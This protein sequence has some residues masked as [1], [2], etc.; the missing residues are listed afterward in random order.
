MYHDVDFGNAYAGLITVGY[1]VLDSAGG[2]EIARTTSGVFEIG[3]GKYG[4]NVNLSATFAGTIYWDTVDG[5]SVNACEAI[6]NSFNYMLAMPGQ[7]T[8]SLTPS[9]AQAIMQ[10]YQRETNPMDQD[11]ASQK[12]YSRDGVTVHQKRA[13]AEVG[14]V[15]SIGAVTAGP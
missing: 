11:G 15:T 5:G 7:V 9:L 4:A 3:H 8:P 14:G 1:K 2:V 13:V 6:D 12:I 10:L